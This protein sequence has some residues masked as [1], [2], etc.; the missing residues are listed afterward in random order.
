MGFPF[1]ILV[2]DPQTKLHAPFDI[3]PAKQG[4]T[5][6]EHLLDW[7]CEI[8]KSLS[9]RFSSD[10]LYKLTLPVGHNS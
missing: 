10:S 6:A 1:H 4:G 8:P 7:N 9:R 5:Q 3:R 2:S